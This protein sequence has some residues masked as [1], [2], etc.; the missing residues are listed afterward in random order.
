MYPGELPCPNDEECPRMSLSI[1]TKL[2]GGFGILL[3]LMA[4]VSLVAVTMISSVNH[5]AVAVGKDGVAAETSLAE[6]GQTMNKL[7]KDQI[8]YMVVAPP[9]RADVKGDIAGDLSDMA[10]FF[11]T[12][13]GT[14]T[15]ERRSLERFE[16]AW[17]A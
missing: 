1:R 13:A 9:S 14:T 5:A 8:H 11:R 12:Y 4:A 2:F 10:G 6:V 16:S 7:R 15:A 3:V 17:T